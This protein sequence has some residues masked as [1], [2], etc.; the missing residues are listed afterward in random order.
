ASY[1]QNHRGNRIEP[2]LAELQTPATAVPGVNRDLLPL[3][4]T[5]Q[6]LRAYPQALQWAEVCSFL[7]P[8][9]IPTSYLTEWFRTR[10]EENPQEKT[11]E[12]L[13]RLTHHGVI[14]YD[15]EQGTLSIHRFM[16]AVLKEGDSHPEARGSEVS[17]ILVNMIKEFDKNNVSSW[18]LVEPWLPHALF[19]LQSERIERAEDRPSLAEAFHALNLVYYFKVDFTKA[20]EMGERSLAIY[21]ELYEG[22]HPDVATSLNNSGDV[23]R[24]LGRYAEAL[25]RCEESLAM[26]RAL[27]GEGPHPDVATSLNN[28]G[29]TLESLGRYAEALERY[30]ESLA[31][32]RS[33]YSGNEDHPS[34]QQTKRNIQNCQAKTKKCLIA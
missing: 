16:H 9:A 31:I 26:R 13:Y 10:G 33:L 34:I 32:D 3:I 8:D 24:S 25:E 6:T 7:N 2:Y 17:Q 30:E 19:A 18:L 22:P 11:R 1:L 4:A 5:L 20:L 15:R 27:F 28:S 21:R 14:T 12:I 23:L 29:L